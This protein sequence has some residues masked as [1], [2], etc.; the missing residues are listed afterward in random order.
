MKIDDYAISMASSHDLT[1][2]SHKEETLVQW[3][4]GETAQQAAYETPVSVKL[5]SQA[6]ENLQEE[7]SSL[8]I[9]EIGNGGA[10]LKLSPLSLKYMIPKIKAEKAEANSFLSEMD[11]LKIQLIEELLYRA[12]GKKIKIKIFDPSKSKKESSSASLS[13]EASSEKFQKALKIGEGEKEEQRV[14][15][16]LDYHY[17]EEH[18]ESEKTS[19]DAQGVVKTKD[20]REIHLDVSVNMSREFYTRKEISLKAGDALIDPLVINFNG[21]LAELSDN[22]KIEFDLDMDGKKDQIS[23]LASD[24]GYLALDKNNDGKIN[25][26]GELFGPESGNGFDDLAKY[27]EDGNGWIDEND[28]VFDK[29]RVW[30][31]DSSGKEVLMAL[32]QTGVGAIYLGREKTEFAITS[33]EN[34]NGQL[35]ESGI[36]LKENGIVGTIQELDLVV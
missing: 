20:G 7:H 1:K 13:D 33:N 3:T 12:T 28:S 4:G 25:D 16:G 36:Y 24:S 22:D 9:R 29:L 35:R 18:Y 15:W 8:P 23:R 26:G 27:D 14:G 2:Y 19:F 30:N 10:S 5:S 21:N 31:K 34:L 32:G 11:K 17:L 6:L